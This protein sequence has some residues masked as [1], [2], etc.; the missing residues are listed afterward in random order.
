MFI[1]NITTSDQRHLSAHEKAENIASAIRLFEVVCPDGNYGCH[2]G[3]IASLEMLHSL[4]LWLDGEKDGA[5]GALD[6][7]RDHDLK[8]ISVC[9]EGVARYTAPLVRLAEERPTCSAEQARQDYQTMAEDWP[10]W[11]VPEAEQVKAEMQA[12][13]RWE[14]WASGILE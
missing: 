13:P 1:V 11:E 2:H 3:Y 7:A 12:N 8:F 14:E 5:F 10:W 9:E 6:R 4:Y